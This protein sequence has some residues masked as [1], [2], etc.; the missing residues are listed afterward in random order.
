MIF[1]IASRQKITL[2]PTLLPR[3]EG[4]RVRVTGQ[5][6]N[7]VWYFGKVNSMNQAKNIT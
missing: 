4:L 1:S 6:K 3:R 5:G 7:L 2:I